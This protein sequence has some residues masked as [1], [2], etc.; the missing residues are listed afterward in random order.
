M[1]G[2]HRLQLTPCRVMTKQG[3]NSSRFTKIIL[4]IE[5]SAEPAVL[6]MQQTI[7]PPEGQQA[8]PPGRQDT[9]AVLGAQER[10]TRNQKLYGMR[11]TGFG[12]R[13]AFWHQQDQDTR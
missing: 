9:M 2:S 4:S 7:R 6:K 5:L 1:S 10:S 12:P 8:Q 13:D 3:S 11:D